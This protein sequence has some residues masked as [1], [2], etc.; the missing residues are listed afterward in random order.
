[1]GGSNKRKKSELREYRLF[2]YEYRWGTFKH[3]PS[4]LAI[5][6]TENFFRLFLESR[7]PACSSR[8]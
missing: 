2:N 3:K 1:V 6:L 5:E 4:S 8:Y 7:P